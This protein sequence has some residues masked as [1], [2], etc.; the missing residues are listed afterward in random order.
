MDQLF[1]MYLGHVVSNVCNLLGKQLG[2]L[3]L[4]KMGNRFHANV[5]TSHLLR[6]CQTCQASCTMRHMAWLS[7]FGFLQLV[8][9][10]N[11]HWGLFMVLY[12]RLD[13]LHLTQDLCL[14]CGVGKQERGWNL[15]HMV[16]AQSPKNPSEN[17]K[18]QLQ[19]R[20]VTAFLLLLHGWTHGNALKEMNL[21]QSAMFGHC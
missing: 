17:Y 1:V 8:L 11:Q 16:Q 5:L 7:S 15:A 13:L 6:L 4:K 14:A 3:T 9:Y 10:L 2:I 18:P 21:E 12:G 20:A 19:R